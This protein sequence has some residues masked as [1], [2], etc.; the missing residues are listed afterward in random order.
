[1]AL[2]VAAALAPASA[3]AQSVGAAGKIS[4]AHFSQLPVIE[5]PLLS[6]N[7]KWIAARANAGG[8]TNIVLIN[9]DHPRA[10]YRK[11]KLNEFKI[12]GL[13]W[14]GNERLLLTVQATEKIGGEDLAFLRLIAIDTGSGLSRIVDPKSRGIYAGDVIYADPSGQWA[15]VV[16]QDNVFE[17]PSVKRANLATG[18]ATLVEKARHNVWD[19]YADD[20]GVVRAGIAY[21]GRR[22]TVWYRDNP[23]EK[24]RKLRGKI[25]KDDESAVDRIIFGRGQNNWIV[26]NGRTGRFALYRYDL[27]TG[28]IG[29]AIMERPDVDIGDVFYNST[30]GAIT[31]VEYEDDRNRIAWLD[32][33]LRALQAKIDRALPDAVNIPTDWSL[34]EN[35]VLV[36]SSSAADPGA[37]FLLDRATSKMHAVAEPYPQID[38]KRLSLVKAVRYQARDG[39]S[40]PGYL[41]LPRGRDPRGLPLIVMPHGGPFVRDHWDYDPMVQFLAN[42]GY[43]V[44]QPQFRGSTGYG[45]DFVS[46]GYG[47]WGRRMQDDLDDGVD[48]LVRSGQVD[49]KRVCIVGASYGG[50]AA[51]WGAIRNPE[52]YRCAASMAG[53]ADLPRMLRY[54][55]KLFSATRYYREWQTMVGGEGK[56]DLA[57]VSPI[58]FASRLKVPVLI[59]HG[60]K[61]DN[62][63]VKQSRAMVDALT[64]ANGKVTSV[65]YKDGGHGFNSSADLEDWLKRLEAFLATH[66]PA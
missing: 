56:T 58:N 22:W 28:A 16:S 26:T 32:P 18:A 12:A 15:L 9:A 50:Y 53:V 30:T 35:R 49:P 21:E 19:W 54:D 8:K 43:A 2:A 65:F 40:L 11:I 34:D 51:M 37:Y 63:P 25:A 62:V 29:E 36:W 14:A 13:R 39:L 1:M 5:Q 10:Q 59:G 7:G 24:L 23:G 42:R 48:W 6:P 60:E 45:K 27:K 4:T 33:H 55:R 31:A 46:R 44:L 17:Y 61:D 64:K 66:N 38:P 3:T 20:N 41:T 47:E 52:R 57:A